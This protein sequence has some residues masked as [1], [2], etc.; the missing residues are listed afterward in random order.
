MHH[1]S[2]QYSGSYASGKVKALTA[3]PLPL[4]FD[5]LDQDEAEKEE[6]DSLQ[7]GLIIAPLAALVSAIAG[8]PQLKEQC[9]E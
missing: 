1:V 4:T 7:P 9:L 6:E 5:L 2:G 8:V 3:L